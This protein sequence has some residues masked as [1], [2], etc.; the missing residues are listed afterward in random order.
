M[1]L[2][3]ERLDDH[4]PVAMSRQASAWRA[5]YAVFAVELDVQWVVDV[6]AGADGDADAVCVLRLGY[7]AV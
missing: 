1:E 3:A 2:G 4:L 7:F 6:A 5:P